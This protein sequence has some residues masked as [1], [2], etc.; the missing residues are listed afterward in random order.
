MSSIPVH[1]ASYGGR[2]APCTQTAKSKMRLAVSDGLS[3]MYCVTGNHGKARDTRV[4]GIS[5][6]NA[7]LWPHGFP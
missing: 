5:G 4:S 6:P 7:A 2:A 3:F 1:R